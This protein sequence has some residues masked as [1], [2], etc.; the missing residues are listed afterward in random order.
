MWVGTAYIRGCL[1][2]GW[3]GTA[4]GEVQLQRREKVWMQS[5][6]GAGVE[7]KESSLGIGRV[8]TYVGVL[9]DGVGDALSGEII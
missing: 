8:Q 9:G 7:W 2:G 1:G 6:G 4:A 5:K 3:R